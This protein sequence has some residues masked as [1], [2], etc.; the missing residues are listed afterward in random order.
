M[1]LWSKR[2]LIA[3]EVILVFL[4]CVKSKNENEK[5]VS[6]CL[7]NEWALQTEVDWA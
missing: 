1:L 2:Q 5:L 3:A 7:L 6:F 4:R